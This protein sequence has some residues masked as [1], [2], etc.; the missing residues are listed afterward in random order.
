MAYGF[1]FQAG[2]KQ[3]IDKTSIL[4]AFMLIQHERAK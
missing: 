1:T 3:W 4:P 2:N